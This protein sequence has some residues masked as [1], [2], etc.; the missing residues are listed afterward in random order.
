MKRNFNNNNPFLNDWIDEN[1]LVPSINMNESYL[2]IDFLIIYKNQIDFSC[3]SSNE[4]DVAIKYIE[5]NINN[6]KICWISILN[7]KNKSSIKLVEKNHNKI[8]EWMYGLPN[9][10]EKDHEILNYWKNLSLDEINN[11]NIETINWKYL[12]INPNAIELFKKYQNNID[13]YYFSMNPAI[14]KLNYDFFRKRCDIFRQDLAKKTMHPNKI[15]NILNLELEI[16][17]DF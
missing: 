8:E 15:L 5:E 10:I 4:S 6:R 12:S 9:L 7:N 2:L 14:F 13:W 1:K 17:D 11:L 3:L 16:E